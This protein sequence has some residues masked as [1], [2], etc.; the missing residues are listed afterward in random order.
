MK[1][2]RCQNIPPP[3]GKRVAIIGAGPAGLGAAGVLRCRGHDVIVFDMLPEAGGMMFFG[4]P[5]DR[6]NKEKIRASVRELMDAGVRFVLNTKVGRDIPLGKIIESFDAILIATG[7]WRTRR[8]DVPGED[9]PWVLQAAEWLVEV[10]MARYGHIPWGEVVKPKGRILVVGAG[11]T[12]ADIVTVLLTYHELKSGVEEVVLSYR[13]TRELAPMRLSEFE[14]LEK[15]GA[16]IWELT[17]PIAFYEKDGSR[18]TRFIKM[19]LEKVAGEKRPKPQ[20]IPGSEFEE[21]FDY[22]FKAI[23]EEP[24]PPFEPGEYGIELNPDGTIKTNEHFM[25]TR[26]KVFAAGDV[27]HGPSLIGPALKSGLDVA[28]KIHEYLTGLI[29]WKLK[30]ANIVAHLIKQP[31]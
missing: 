2:L 13:R 9:L 20:P 23:G 21:E 30:P 10:H 26:E 28:Q 8:L 5:D 27:K 22:V 15:L 4:I 31:P 19:K 12:A 3:T 1:F 6:V 29:T 17:Q 16:K 24:T 18:V 14:R 11:L 7:T 25:T